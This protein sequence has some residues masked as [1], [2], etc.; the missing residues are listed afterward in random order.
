MT[1][2]HHTTPPELTAV[3]RMVFSTRRVKVAQWRCTPAFADFGDTGPIRS[4]L[5]AFPRTSV[6]IRHVGGPE[7][8]ADPTVV[9]IYNRAQRYLRERL[10]PAGDLCD[11]WGVD[12]ETA[13][14][15][16]AS[17]DAGAHQGRG[18]PFRFAVARCSHD[19]Y[20][21]QRALLHRLSAGD[22]D[23]LE[24]EEAV[25]GIVSE[26]LR[27]A[28]QGQGAS[29]SGASGA[30][31]A[32]TRHRALAQSALALLAVRHRENLSLDDVARALSA[33]PF[34]LCRVFRAQ[35]GASLHAQLTSVRLRT[36]LECIE[37]GA[38]DLTQVAL[39]A[40][41]ASHSHFSAAFG[42][43]FGVSPSDWRAVT[44]RGRGAVQPLARRR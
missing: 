16:A 11:W 34:H 36:A 40:G 24:A 33:S 41:F 44:A 22:M 31:D 23:E 2:S 12:D 42:R 20:L 35:T 10:H 15:I 38:Q 5:V 29:A 1:N 28:A 30:S 37:Q 18:G 8:V 25:L 9:S 32:S 19:L 7:F 14:E 17:V 6:R 43:A 3:E 4:Q 39:D 27:S 21:R 26:V 13:Q